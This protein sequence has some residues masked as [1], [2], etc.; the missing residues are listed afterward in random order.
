MKSIVIAYSHT[1]RK[2]SSLLRCAALNFLIFNDK[3][4]S[5]NLQEILALRLLFTG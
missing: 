4:V 3:L 2:T 1:C 5:Y